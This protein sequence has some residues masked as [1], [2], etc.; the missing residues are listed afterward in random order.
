MIITFPNVDMRT[1]FIFRVAENN[2]GL[3]IKLTR[4]EPSLTVAD[5]DLSDNVKAQ[6]RD[7]AARFSGTVYDSY[8]LTHLI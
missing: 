6:L 4:T 7:D 3:V 1:C 8:T 2:K 5:G